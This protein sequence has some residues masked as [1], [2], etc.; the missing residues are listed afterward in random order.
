M[1]RTMFTRTISILLAVVAA[2]APLA[3]ADPARDVLVGEHWYVGELNRSPAMT[4]HQVVTRHA[5]GRHT[6]V[7]DTVMVIRRK[8]GAQDFKLEIRESQRFGESS[9]GVVE[10]FRFDHVES[11]STISAEGRV[12]PG[13]GEPDRAVATVHRLGRTQDV[14]IPIPAGVK[15][16]SD[17]VVQA[18]IA[19]D[20]ITAGAKRTFHGLILMNGQVQLVTSTV[21]GKGATPDGD[22]NVEMLADVMP[23]PIQTVIAKNG[24]LVA[25]TMSFGPIGISLKRSSG[26][27]PLLGGEVSPTGMVS[28]KGPAPRSAP[29]NRYRLPATVAVQDDGFSLMAEG[30]VTVRSRGNRRAPTDAE[31]KTLLATEAQIEIDD[32]ALRA[33]VTGLVKTDEAPSATAERL[34][35]AVRSHIGKKDFGVMDGSALETYRS[36]H[37]DCTEHANLLAAALRI[38]G[39]PARVDVGVVWSA[40]H[41]AWVGHAWNTAWIDGRWVHLDAAYPGIERSQYLRLGSPGATKGTMAAMVA[42]L[43]ALMGGEVEVLP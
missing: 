25:M 39:I 9:S 22:W 31:K 38:A 5:D 21:T 8:M 12:E 6:S 40:D 37:G 18:E 30:V 42:N 10:T 11:G 27:V 26:P 41:G 17:R 32:P 7:I 36:R 2:L 29:E 16:L 20:P 14:V 43:S 15:L 35:L 13:R 4:L 19:R 28:A 1:N 34:R 3:A 33:W 23:I 24:E